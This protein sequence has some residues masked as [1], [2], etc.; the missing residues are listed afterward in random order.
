MKILIIT[1]V[2]PPEPV[3]S[4]KLSFDIAVGISENNTVTVISPKPSRPLGFQFPD[5]SEEY[6]FKHI[7]LNSYI[8]ASSSISGRIKESYSF[9]RHCYRYIRDNHQNIDVIYANTWPLPAQYFAVKAAKKYQ[10]PII[11]HIQ[12]IYPESISQKIPSLAKIINLALRP[13]DKYIL[14][15]ATRVIAISGK[16]KTYL[17]KTRSLRDTQVNVI[18]NWQDESLY[19]NPVLMQAN[20]QFTY[21]YLGSISPAAGVELLIHAFQKA[22]I[23]NARLIIAGNGSDKKLCMDIATNYQNENIQFMDAPSHL[24]PSIQAT[25]DVLLLPL[26]KG[27]GLTASPSKL[28]SYMFTSK[29]IIA[30]VDKGSDTE[31]V[32]LDAKCGWV[33]EPGN[34]EKL[35]E[36]MKASSAFHKEVLNQMGE[37]GRRY[38]LEN[39]SKRE[40]LEKL[41]DDI[42]L[43]ATRCK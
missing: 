10:I 7:Q 35:A 21:M 36:I 27:I 9:G 2:F 11:L 14:S 28:P 40:N 18:R 42:N 12:D 17:V 6:N 41:I 22:K 1:A 13:L 34:I 26:K 25:S 43:V 24:V 4:A 38:A 29:P 16:M 30:C 20:T 32:I 15:N 19:F 3:V 8:C 23:P 37:N 31:E 39:Y 33:T 5:T